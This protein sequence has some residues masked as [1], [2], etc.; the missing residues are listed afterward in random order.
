MHETRE[1]EGAHPHLKMLREGKVSTLRT[2]SKRERN[3]NLDIRGI[4]KVLKVFISPSLS[5]FRRFQAS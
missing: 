4:W 2:F 3:Q 1:I 5:T